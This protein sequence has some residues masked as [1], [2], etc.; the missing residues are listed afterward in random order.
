M[1]VY[2]VAEELE[3][4]SIQRSKAGGATAMSHVVRATRA[5]AE[6]L[7]ASVEVNAVSVA[8]A[9]LRVLL[10]AGDGTDEPVVHLRPASV[11]HLLA[12]DCVWPKMSEADRQVLDGCYTPRDASLA[13]KLSTLY[14]PLSDGPQAEIDVELG[15][16]RR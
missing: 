7:A 3:A 2:F 15:A 14:I 11:E 12:V 6:R 8:G 16:V 4:L 13:G 5:V 10:P 1:H 9:D